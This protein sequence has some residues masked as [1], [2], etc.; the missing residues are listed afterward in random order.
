MGVGTDGC[1]RIFYRIISF[2]SLQQRFRLVKMKLHTHWLGDGILIDAS[3]SDQ[4]I[5]WPLTIREEMVRIGGSQYGILG[6]PNVFEYFYDFVELESNLEISLRMQQQ[7]TFAMESLEGNTI[8]VCSRSMQLISWRSPS[9][10]WY[11]L[12]IDGVR[13]PTTGMA[14]CGGVI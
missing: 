13:K 14:A 3:R 5:W 1:L 9:L 12:N 10:G 11:K 8:S 7:Y 2:L 4:F 6:D